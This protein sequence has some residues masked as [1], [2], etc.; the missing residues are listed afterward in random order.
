MGKSIYSNIPILQYFYEKEFRKPLLTI[1]FSTLLISLLDLLST[2]CIAIVIGQIAMNNLVHVSSNT[3]YLYLFA[4]LFF[5]IAKPKISKFIN[6]IIANKQNDVEQLL[7][8]KYLNPALKRIQST[9]GSDYYHYAINMIEGELATI[10]NDFFPAIRLLLVEILF[11]FYTVLYFLVNFPIW[12]TLI[13]V[14]SL[15]LFSL[16]IKNTH[17]KI[18]AYQLKR[19]TVFSLT[20]T[21]LNNLIRG[22]KESYVFGTKKYYFD[23]YLE[24]KNSLTRIKFSQEIENSY[25]K[26]LMESTGLALITLFSIGVYFNLYDISTTNSVI[27]IALAMRLNPSLSRISNAL[28][29]IK[30]TIPITRNVKAAIDADSIFLRNNSQIVVEKSEIIGI[31]VIDLTIKVGERE[32]LSH[33]NIKIVPGDIVAITGQSGAGKTILIETL[34]GLRN[35][36][37]G[38]ILINTK[39]WENKAYLQQDTFILNDDF[40]NNIAFG[41][42]MID[43]ARLMELI[44][45]LDLLVTTE[46]KF[47]LNGSTLSGGEKQRL[48]I[49]RVLVN[50][51]LLIFLDEPTSAQDTARVKKIIDLLKKN[52]NAIIIFVSHNEELSAIANKFIKLG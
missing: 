5:T 1:L 9:S 48:G 39:Y 32:L 6:I 34:A 23:K 11:L 13:S 44:T 14:V 47:A 29:R 30:S 25:E 40:Y 4:A 31:D 33:L 20:L 7:L 18:V 37:A 15:S 26:N 45:D 27:I 50:A 21:N 17:N 10:F 36:N 8:I 28:S 16:I 24:S 46:N 35:P 52:R 42:D 22:L 43:N 3:T 41:R 49:A 19:S 2:L 12:V 38:R 51:S